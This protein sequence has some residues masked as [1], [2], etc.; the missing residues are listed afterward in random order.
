MVLIAVWAFVA[1]YFLSI[2][3]AVSLEAAIISSSFFVFFAAKVTLSAIVIA[4]KDRPSGHQSPT[5]RSPAA[6]QN[7]PPG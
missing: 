3:Y 2:C 6:N 4:L 5:D 7:H 1:V